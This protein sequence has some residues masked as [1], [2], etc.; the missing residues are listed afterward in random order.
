METFVILGA[1]FVIAVS[2]A[3][4][5]VRALRG[6]TLFDRVLAFDCLALNT[7][8]GILLISLLLHTDAFLDVVLVVAL[9]GFLGTVALATYLEGTIVDS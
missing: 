1:L 3:L 9:L 5:M 6:P 8:G 4:C 2:I 7:V